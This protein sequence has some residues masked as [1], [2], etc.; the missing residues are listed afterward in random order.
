MTNLKT[1][2]G[3][4]QVLV[5]GTDVDGNLERARQMI[6]DAAKQ[7]CD[8]IVLPECLDI[9]WTHPAARELAREIPGEHSDFLCRTARDSNI[10]IAAGLTERFRDRIYNS[11]VL[12]SP[13][14]EIILKHRKINI[15]DIAQDLYSIGDS[16]SVVDTP[17]ARIGITICADNFPNSLALGHSLARMGAQLILSPCAWAAPTDY[18]NVSQPYDKGWKESYGRLSELYN[19]T[20]VGVSNVGCLS[21]GP[22]MGYDCIGGSIAM[23]P[24]GRVLAQLPYDKNSDILTVIETEI[25]KPEKTGT[26]IAAMLTEKGYNGP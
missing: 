19:I 26:D 18:D 7:G 2:I 6:I 17:L 23:G 13:D 20:T 15:L 1:K 10:Y 12:V 14:G 11:A 9:G 5:K 21:A 16:L 25:I 24:Q 4:G 8:I 22:W 3:M